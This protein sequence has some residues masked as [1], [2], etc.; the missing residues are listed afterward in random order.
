[1]SPVIAAALIGVGGAVIV[2][3]AGFLTT[4]TI[5][6]Q[7]IN[8][9]A[10]AAREGRLWDKRAAAYESAL[11]ELAQRQARRER[12]QRLQD[13]GDTA[14]AQKALA[15][16]FATRDTPAW[17]AAEGRLLAYSSNEVRDA[18]EAARRAGEAVSEAE[19]RAEEAKKTPGQVSPATQHEEYMQLLHAIFDTAASD[20]FLIRVI[21]FE[22]GITREI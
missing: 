13:A 12:F 4:R 11:I 15:D 17:A 6:I 1:M 19:E 3:V 8:A 20:A 16:Y 7:T 2:A 5:T 18:L 14:V 22:L 10:T 21:Q 9:A